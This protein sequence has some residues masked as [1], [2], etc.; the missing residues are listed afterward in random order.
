MRFCGWNAPENGRIRVFFEL[1][2]ALL[3]RAHSDTRNWRK[4]ESKRQRWAAVAASLRAHASSTTILR[5]RVRSL[6]AFDRTA[7]FPCSARCWSCLCRR[8]ATAADLRTA[9][10]WIE[11]VLPLRRQ[12]LPI[13]VPQLPTRT[14]RT[15]TRRMARNGRDSLR[16]YSGFM[17]HV[18]KL[19]SWPRCK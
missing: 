19:T 5:V 13:K 7:T 2:V 16:I 8:A 15:V 18:G 17:T 9:P 11:S 4:L 3:W 10:R 12:L 6:T 14:R 1:I